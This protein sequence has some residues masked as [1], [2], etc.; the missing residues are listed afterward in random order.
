[1]WHT[2]Y[3]ALA[4][5]AACGGRPG[6]ARDSARTN[7]AGS[8]TM[9][10]QERLREM[11][12]VSPTLVEPLRDLPAA[13]LENRFVHVEVVTVVNPRR[14]PV[15]VRVDYAPPTGNRVHLGS[16][17]LFPSDRPGKF[18]VATQGRVSRDGSI[19]LSLEKPGAATPSDTVRIAIRPITLVNR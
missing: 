3:F 5:A 17:S 19:V 12:L 13:S 16:F 7:N 18:I 4:L 9:P 11:N 15:T 8:S 6:P 1:M 2:F 14:L 10:P